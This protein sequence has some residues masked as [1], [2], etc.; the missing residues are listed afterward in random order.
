MAKVTLND[1][2]KM[3]YDRV[4]AA[5]TAQGSTLLRE[6]HQHK[7]V[8]GIDN[9]NPPP[10]AE[11]IISPMPTEALGPSGSLLRGFIEINVYSKGDDQGAYDPAEEA[12]KYL[13]LFPP[14]GFGQDGIS[15]IKEGTI[16]RP[17][18]DRSRPGWRYTPTLIQY[19]A[20]SCPV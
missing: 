17:L 12:Q 10:Y 5:R 16:E 2:Q 15:I 3:V 20:R 18:D 1:I 13:D 8:Y 6:K 4:K 11:I 7:R 9:A 19:E 14:E